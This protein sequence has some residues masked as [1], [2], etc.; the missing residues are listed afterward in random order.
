MSHALKIPTQPL[1]ADDV[2]TVDVLLV[3]SRDAARMLA[4]SERTLWTLSH[5]GSIPRVK[6]KS[7]VRFSVEDLKNWIV[8]QKQDLTRTRD[9]GGD[10]SPPV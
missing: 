2:A 6:V 10:G 9:S 1:D 3:T 5:D 4:V 8:T 7:A